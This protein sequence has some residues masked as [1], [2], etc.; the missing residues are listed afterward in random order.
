M[1]TQQKKEIEETR[2]ALLKLRDESVG[3]YIEETTAGRRVMIVMA[4]NE[5]GI[6]C[7]F[8]K[9]EEGL[10]VALKTGKVE[11]IKEYSVRD[12]EE[13]V[14]LQ[15]ISLMVIFQTGEKSLFEQSRIQR[16]TCDA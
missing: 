1:N 2:E 12:D 13:G 5:H 6:S 16:T 9:T 4:M 8:K 15:F 7:S 11:A 3:R 14:Y 10:T